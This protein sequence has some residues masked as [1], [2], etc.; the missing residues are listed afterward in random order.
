MP[1]RKSRRRSSRP[2]RPAARPLPTHDAAGVDLTLIRW[3]LSLTPRQR[4]EVLRRNI[5][6]IQ[7]LRHA[8]I[9]S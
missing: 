7:G 4:L 1:A 6:A 5:R 3:A 2:S 8:R 9:R